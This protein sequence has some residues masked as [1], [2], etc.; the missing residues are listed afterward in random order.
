MDGAKFWRLLADYT[1][2]HT[3]KW[4]VMASRST[5]YPNLT[6]SDLAPFLIDGLGELWVAENGCGDEQWT[7]QPSLGGPAWTDT[8]QSGYRYNHATFMDLVLSGVVGLQPHANGTLLVNP[9]VPAATLPWWA[10]DGVALHGKIVSVR[11]DADGSHYNSSAG[12][13]VLVNGATAASSPALKPL[14]VQLR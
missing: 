8:P 7:E 3:S 5:F 12:L 13:E 11:F 2:M 1:M 14:V 9:L 6:D 4:R 10:A